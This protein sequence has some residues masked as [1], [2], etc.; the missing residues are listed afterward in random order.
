MSNSIK[1]TA[2]FGIILLVIAHALMLATAQRVLPQV[3]HRLGLATDNSTIESIPIGGFNWD[4]AKANGPINSLPV[5]PSARD[6]I[7]RAAPCLLCV[8]YTKPQPQPAIVPS[9]TIANVSPVAVDQTK[10]NIVLFVESDAQS[11]QLLDWFN[12]DPALYKLR[13]R[14]NFQVYTSSNPLYLSRYAQTVPKQAFPAMLFGDS[15]GGLVH[16]F[17]RDL[18]PSN[19][20]QLYADM[21]HAYT[22]QQQVVQT[23]KGIST[24][25]STNPNCPDG[26][27]DQR[28]PWL[29]PDRDRVLPSM[30]DRSKDDGSIEGIFRAL[31]NP[32]KT[33]ETAGMIVLVIVGAIVAIK[34]L[35]TP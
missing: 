28:E 1:I 32:I 2:S 21:S 10:Y 14:C 18:M 29:N 13:A 6:E 8:Q 24:S 35:R 4:R 17:N 31:L 3:E 33:M 5:N 19:P 34:Y 27:C 16:S 9:R 22:L 15:S 7:K 23:R 12:R 30:F 20:T 26:N 25:E 11:Q